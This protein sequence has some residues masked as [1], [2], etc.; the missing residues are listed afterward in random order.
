MNMYIDWYVERPATA[1]TEGLK[2]RICLECNFQDE[3]KIPVHVHVWTNWQF[4]NGV[5]IRR[6]K[7][8]GFENKG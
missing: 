7:E 8:C 6:C 2:V 1:T 5:L 4:E 3:E